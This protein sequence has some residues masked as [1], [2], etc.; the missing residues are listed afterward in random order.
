M[1]ILPPTI[2]L[3]T[4][5][6]FNINNFNRLNNANVYLNNVMRENLYNESIRFDEAVR[7]A[8]T[9]INN[10]SGG[11]G[12][13]ANFILG[14]DRTAVSREFRTL[15]A[16]WRAGEMDTLPLGRFIQPDGLVRTP[17]AIKK[18]LLNQVKAIL[19]F[20]PHIPDV[21]IKSQF[22][23]DIPLPVRQGMLNFQDNQQFGL[24]HNH[25]IPPDNN[26]YNPQP[27]LPRQIIP[28][29]NIPHPR[30]C[31]PRDNSTYG[32][33]SPH[34]QLRH[35]KSK[36][37]PIR[38]PGSSNNF[39]NPHKSYISPNIQ[40]VPPINRPGTSRSFPPPP[41]HSSPKKSLPKKQTN[42]CSF[43]EETDIINK[44]IPR[45]Y[46]P[47]SPLL[48]NISVDTNNN[49][50]SIPL[51]K[52]NPFPKLK[53]PFLKRKLSPIRLNESTE[54]LE[55]SIAKNDSFLS[56]PSPVL[57][58]AK[59]SQS[60]LKSKNE[61]PDQKIQREKGYELSIQSAIANIEKFR[62][63]Q[64]DKL[65]QQINDAKAKGVDSLRN[66]RIPK[67]YATVVLPKIPNFNVKIIGDSTAKRLHT[68]IVDI[69]HN[70]NVSLLS[71]SSKDM[72]SVTNFLMADIATIKDLD[73]NTKVV[74]V[75]LAGQHDLTRATGKNSCELNPSF[76]LSQFVN[77]ILITEL[78]VKD[79]PK[80]KII[81]TIPLI[82]DFKRY[83]NSLRNK[84]VSYNLS[85]TY[86]YNIFE[87]SMKLREYNHRIDNF[88][89]SAA[90]NFI[91]IQSIDENMVAF[92][93]DMPRIFEQKQNGLGF[94]NNNTT[95]DGLHL[96]GIGSNALWAKIENIINTKF[97][98]K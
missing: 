25:F 86:D 94:P 30:F 40:H 60:S 61:T 77:N 1:L 80:V 51:D 62:Q 14:S 72:E 16:K 26:V 20:F 38:H 91:N 36:H 78:F 57:K 66:Y 79:H 44:P 11:Y 42:I 76:N 35:F 27:N 54:S 5:A 8:I 37:S 22:I 70:F 29:Q 4:N 81:W 43:T 85:N 87:K 73:E 71:C 82:T 53:K 65:N 18:L 93:K 83:C 41:K 6:I 49:D 95:C 2:C 31:R 98:K 47:Q 55:K 17:Y 45:Y 28:H 88:M 97:S 9:D 59:Y 64:F 10:Q 58:K 89:L 34:G 74:Y 3:V 19:S 75:V 33:K 21:F 46:V 48:P 39:Q 96:N 92:D 15:R 56:N 50:K 68:Q 7:Q 63:I 90:C 23:N 84:I 67:K 69:P 13:V 24:A 12:H 32:Y 52:T